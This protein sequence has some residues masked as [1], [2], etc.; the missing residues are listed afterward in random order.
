MT[1]VYIQTVQN[2]ERG[3]FEVWASIPKIS[4]IRKTER[5]ETAEPQKFSSNFH[6]DTQSPTRKMWTRSAR[7]VRPDRHGPTLAGSV[8]AAVR[9]RSRAGAGHSASTKRRCSE[10]T[11]RGNARTSFQGFHPKVTNA[12]LYLA[13]TGAAFVV[14]E[15]RLMAASCGPGEV[16]ASLAGKAPQSWFGALSLP[17]FARRSTIRP[18]GPAFGR[19]TFCGRAREYSSYRNYRSGMIPPSRRWEGVGMDSGRKV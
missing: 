8:R 9:A 14:S 7:I 6:T 17:A 13:N 1:V 18:V 12:V 16:E 11:V 2:G 15:S 10:N 3:R 19:P 4:K 5:A